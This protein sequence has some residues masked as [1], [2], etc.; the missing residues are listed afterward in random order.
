MKPFNLETVLKYR[1]RLKDQ[2]RN[3]FQEAQNQRNKSHDDFV[4]KQKEYLNLIDTITK[5]QHQGVAVDE[6]I[7]YQNRIE[8]ISAELIKRQETLRKKTEYLVRERNHLIKKN[9]EERV[10]KKLKETQNLEYQKFIDKKE[11]AML[12]E[13]AVLYRNQQDS[14]EP[15]EVL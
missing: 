11:S 3:R 14:T 12:D 9:K 7:R 6:H 5:L 13:I 10:L 15:R 8:F 1:K 2:A 4:N